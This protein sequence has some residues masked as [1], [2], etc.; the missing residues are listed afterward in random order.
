MS[1]VGY[2]IQCTIQSTKCHRCNGRATY[3]YCAD[4]Y[5]WWFVFVLASH[6]RLP[7]IDRGDCGKCYRTHQI[8]VEGFIASAASASASASATGRW[9]WWWCCR[10][11]LISSII[12]IIIIDVLIASIIISIMALIFFTTSRYSNCCHDA[13]DSSCFLSTPQQC[14]YCLFI[15]CVLSWLSIRSLTFSRDGNCT[16]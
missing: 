4:R 5:R 14:A 9:W 10:R 13:D 15:V 11:C 6:C 2:P 12:I 16:V 7:S 8:A 3:G 1:K